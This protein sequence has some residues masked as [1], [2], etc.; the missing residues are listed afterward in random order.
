M[1]RLVR[2]DLLVWLRSCLQNTMFE[3]LAHTVGTFSQRGL[4]DR[5]R[6]SAEA[7]DG[8]RRRGAGVD[9]IERGLP[10]VSAA[11][12]YLGHWVAALTRFCTY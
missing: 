9:S 11:R 5:E 6:L 1:A 4:C 12:A 2:T 3:F 8:A 7:L 10:P